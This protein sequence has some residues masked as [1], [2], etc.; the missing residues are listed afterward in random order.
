LI[1][2]LISHGFL[3]DFLWV[4]KFDEALATP[5]RRLE[6]GM[7]GRDI[8]PIAFDQTHYLKMGH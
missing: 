1:L 6:R 4:D 3:V 5:N 2:G 8:N 7:G